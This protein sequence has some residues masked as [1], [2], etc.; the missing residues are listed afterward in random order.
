MI[1]ES[2]TACG[3]A[4]IL[5]NPGPVN[6]SARVR[7][8]LAGP[9][10]CHR[11]PE[12]YRLQADIR[13][14]LLA[15]YALDAARWAPVVL[16]GSGTAAVEA[17]LS[18]LVPAA[19]R[20]LVIE[21][22]VYG[23]RMSRMAE[24]H[25]LRYSRLSF[26]WGAAIDPDALDRRLADGDISHIAVVHHETTTGRLNE[27]S[28]LGRLC[29]ARGVTLLVDAV[30]SFGAEAIDFDAA[31]IGACAATANK[32][33]HGAPGAAF[34]IVRRAA[35]EQAEPRCLYLDLA[36]YC[37]AQDADSTPFTP[38]IPCFY[39]LAEALAE[40]AEQGG[41]AARGAHYRV[42]ADQ[43]E[44]GLRALGIVPLLDARQ[45]SCV[46]RAYHLPGGMDY[47][48]LHDGLK[49]RGFVIYAGQGDLARTVFRVST[50]GELTAD[51]MGRF[52][53]A[54]GEVSGGR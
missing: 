18:S 54:V 2:N 1:G 6:L 20:L 51:D 3:D 53:N 19:G 12:F 16:S 10:L 33:L 46:L 40:H 41:V 32:C 26:A 48:A 44:S 35:L 31:G 42:L 8:A 30:S 24:L 23:E 45:S 4:M 13:A 34:V 17:M 5:L 7:A 11:E 27:L 22:G 39:A 52:V 47:D 9:D 38:S 29:R 49:R 36:G 37:R 43:V 28:E 21:N 15:V 14:R 50:M 25:G